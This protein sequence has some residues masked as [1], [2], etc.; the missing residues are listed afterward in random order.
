VGGWAQSSQ[1]YKK[2]VLVLFPDIPILNIPL[3]S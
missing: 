1:A 3:S 2:I